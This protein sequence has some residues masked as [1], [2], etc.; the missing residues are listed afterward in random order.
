MT[1]RMF[2]DSLLNRRLISCRAVCDLFASPY[3]APVWLKRPTI[4]M[5]PFHQVS[6]HV[7]CGLHPA[8]HRPQR[9]GLQLCS[10]ASMQGKIQLGRAT[11][12]P[13]RKP[14]SGLLTLA[15]GQASEV[16]RSFELARWM[17]RNLQRH[18]WRAMSHQSEPLVGTRSRPCSGHGD[19]SPDFPQHLRWLGRRIISTVRDALH[20]GDGRHSQTSATSPL[21]EPLARP[22]LTSNPG[23]ISAARR[24]ARP[25]IRASSGI[26]GRGEQDKLRRRP[27][28]LQVSGQPALLTSFVV[29]VLNGD[30]Y[31]GMWWASTSRQLPATAGP[32]T[33]A[34]GYSTGGA[35]CASSAPWAS[36]PPTPAMA[37]GQTALQV[38]P[39]WPSC[40]AWRGRRRTAPMA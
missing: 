12:R 39:C 7:L 26:S 3:N 15:D 27:L 35:G 30:Q 1:G 25:G 23:G 40:N 10:L 36:S 20:T 29:P 14:G 32:L 4:V 24:R 28:R 6:S 37:T 33:S 16:A 19:R 9:G 18:C 5:F 34:D 13:A 38:H 2:E 31:L 8:D 11:T 17:R 22:V 21:L